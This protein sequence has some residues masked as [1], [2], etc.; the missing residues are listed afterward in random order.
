M[1]DQTKVRV[2]MIGAGS[3]ANHV[4]YP[5]LAS[6]ADVE[7]AAICDL[8]SQRLNSTADKYHVQQRFIDY[9]QMIEAVAPDAVYAIGQ[10]HMMFDIWCWC[11][12]NGLNLYIEKP[13]GIT[14]HQAARTGCI[15]PKQSSVSPR[16]AF[17]GAVAQWSS[18]Y[19]TSVANVGRLSMP[20]VRSSNASQSPISKRVTTCW[21]MASMPL[22]RC[23][24]SVAV[25]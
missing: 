13:M 4:H 1:T 7:I 18:I 11:L 24:G 12:R 25:R 19:T 15:W 3:M 21:M 14:L 9:R 6:F 2:A 16:S 10:P 22:T 17:N 5:S 8:D 20:S 23:A